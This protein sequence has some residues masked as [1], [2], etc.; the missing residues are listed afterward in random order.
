M[1]APQP[2]PFLGDAL[3]AARVLHGARAAT[4]LDPARRAPLLT[5]PNAP[6]RA[7]GHFSGMQ[8]IPL[9]TANLRASLIRELVRLHARVPQ[10]GASVEILDGELYAQAEH[11]PLVKVD[12]DLI[13]VLRR[14]P[15]GAGSDAV[16]AVLV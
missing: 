11:G 3:P 12:A 1:S 9:A 2:E 10:G 14:L 7:A 8:T 13:S 4:Y 5:D 15:D 16:A 6:Q